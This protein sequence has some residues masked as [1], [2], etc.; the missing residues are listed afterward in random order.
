ML[1]SISKLA[2]AL[3]LINVFHET[4][5]K[6]FYSY[7]AIIINC[8]TF[9]TFMQSCKQKS[10]QKHKQGICCQTKYVAHLMNIKKHEIE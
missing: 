6:T 4:F 10:C 8:K 2:I 9:S 5:Y 7:D 3:M 1:W